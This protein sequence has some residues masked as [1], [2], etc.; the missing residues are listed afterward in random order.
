MRISTL[1]PHDTPLGQSILKEVMQPLFECKRQYAAP[2]VD[3]PTH[4]LSPGFLISVSLY[5]WRKEDNVEK[6]FCSLL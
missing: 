2:F 1:E 4:R 5:R 6:Q 3:L